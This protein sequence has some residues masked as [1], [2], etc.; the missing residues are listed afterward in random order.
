MLDQFLT[1]AY[2]NRCTI[3]TGDIVNEAVWKVF[4]K[5]ATDRGIQLTRTEQINFYGKKAVG[6]NG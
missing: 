1:F 2:E 4:E 6:K 3:Y 5:A